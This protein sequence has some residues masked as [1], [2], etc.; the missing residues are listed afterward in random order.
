MQVFVKSPSQWKSRP[1]S[2]ED[3]RIYKSARHGATVSPVVA[4][5]AYLINLCAVSTSTLERSCDAYED[6]LRRCEALELMGLVVHPGAHTGAGE[7]AGLR[8]IAKS[9]NDIHNRTAGFRTLTLLETTAGQGTSLGSSFTQ[10]KQILDGCRQPERIGICL[11]TCHVFA[12]GHDIRT[13]NG[14]NTMLEELEST[15]GLER[16]KVV[17]VNDSK[18]DVGS[19]VDRHEHIGAGRIGLDGFRHLMNDRRLQDVPKILETDKSDD[20]H[21]D[22]ENM[23]RLRSLIVDWS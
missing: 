17:H 2:D 4:H 7:Q 22:I 5:A 13:A 9:L 11:D 3:V 20:M 18:K 6:E 10:L 21:E 23:E 15:F 16:L 12:A 8:Q 19:H 14:W 1:L